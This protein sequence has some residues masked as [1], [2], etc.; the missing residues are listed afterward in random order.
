M[1]SSLKNHGASS[2]DPQSGQRYR[3]SLMWSRSNATSDPDCISCCSAFP[4]ACGFA[5]WGSKVTRRHMQT[6]PRARAMALPYVVE[7]AE[8]LRLIED[9]PDVV[10][11]FMD[12]VMTLEVM[13]GCICPGLFLAIDP[14]ERA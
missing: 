3:G 5:V 7:R 2:L 9:D 13:R 11:L 4:C 6:R 12:D 10:R 14:K 8:G 1:E